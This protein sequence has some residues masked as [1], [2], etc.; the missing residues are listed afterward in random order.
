MSVC[1]ICGKA[2]LT[3]RQIMLHYCQPH[4]GDLA[5]WR[6]RVQLRLTL[7]YKGFTVA[8]PCG[9]AFATNAEMLQH[10]TSV[11][12]MKVEEPPSP[13]WSAYS[14]EPPEPETPEE[15]RPLAQ[16]EIR[17]KAVER[18]TK[19]VALTASDNPNEADTAARLACKLMREYRMVVS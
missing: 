5:H 12:K 2:D 6:F 18:V 7:L 3:S 15:P 1:L 17:A 16:F 19:L 9:E 4:D 13:Y 14:N 11:H 10:A 8:C